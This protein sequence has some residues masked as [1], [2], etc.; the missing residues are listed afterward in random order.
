VRH[1]S[2]GTKRKLDLGDR[3]D[4]YVEVKSGLSPGGQVRMPG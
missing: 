2:D 1:L 4:A 3:D